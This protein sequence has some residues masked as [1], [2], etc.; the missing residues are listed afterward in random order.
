LLCIRRP[1]PVGDIVLF[2][3]IEAKLLFALQK[4][5]NIGGKRRV[6]LRTLLNFSS[7]PSD[8]LIAVIHPRALAYRLRRDSLKGASQG[9]SCTT[10]AT[11]LV[12][13]IQELA[14][15]A[16]TCSVIWKTSSCTKSH[17]GIGRLL[18][19]VIHSYFL[20]ES[21]LSLRLFDGNFLCAIIQVDW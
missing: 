10:P 19:N 16:R 11:R 20:E 17:N 2:V 13:L 9:S 5:Q 15:A 8:V 14:V 7:P 6:K 12:K 3:Y 21:T 18:I 1:F 4:R